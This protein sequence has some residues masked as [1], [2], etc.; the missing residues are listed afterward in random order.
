MTISK[1]Q[2]ALD[3]L[4]ANPEMTPYQ[5]AKQIGISKTAVYNALSRER[6]RSRCPTCGQLIPE[7]GT[8]VSGEKINRDVLKGE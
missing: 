8:L 2:Q 4:K 7:V 5:A 3:L 6:G 1:T